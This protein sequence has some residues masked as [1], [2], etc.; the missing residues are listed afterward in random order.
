[1]RTTKMLDL[2]QDLRR[3]AA[4]ASAVGD[5]ARKMLEAAA[6]LE[7]QAQRERALASSPTPTKDKSSA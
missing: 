6:E 3:H 1:M 2:A 4:E 5:Y 7:R